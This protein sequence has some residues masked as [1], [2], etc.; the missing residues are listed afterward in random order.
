MLFDTD[1]ETIMPNEKQH[2]TMIWRERMTFDAV[3]TA[4]HQITVDAPP[5]A[6]GN[7]RGPK[8]IELMLTALAGFTAMDV[9]SILQKKREPVEG[10]EVYVEGVRA[11][12]HPMV[13]TDIE[14]VYR[15]RGNVKPASIAR[16]RAVTHE[17]LRRARD[18]A[19]DGAYPHAHRAAAC[20]GAS[21][22]AAQ[23]G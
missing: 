8:P 9:L 10:L 11:S 1:G 19:E 5:E 14:L 21:V 22:N 2:T 15:V 3:T 20:D 7:A 12:E 18:A 17:V 23:C 4:G 6:G 13:Y 16:R